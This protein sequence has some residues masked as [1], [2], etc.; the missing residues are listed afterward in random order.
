MSGEAILTGTGSPD[1]VSTRDGLAGEDHLSW[2]R[3]IGGW[4]AEAVLPPHGVVP[5]IAE[6]GFLR[7]HPALVACIGEMPARWP[8]LAAAGGD[9]VRLEAEE[10]GV[11]VPGSGL[12]P[13]PVHVVAR[14]RAG[15]PTLEVGIAV[16]WDEEHLRGLEVVGWSV[17][18]L[19]G[20]VRRR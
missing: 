20:S 9:L 5:V 4:R 14:M 8:A 11:A 2:R 17:T 15:R 19:D 3:V 12:P 18:G 13:V 16:D 1:A 6:G 10:A 7:P